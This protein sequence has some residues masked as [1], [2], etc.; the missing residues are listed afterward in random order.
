MVI[1]ALDHVRDFIHRGAMSFSPTDLART[2]T[3]I[4]LTRWIT[5]FCAPVFMFTAGM[6]AF[7]WWRQKRTRKQLSV[8]LLTRGLWLV[9]LE[10]TVMRVAYDFNFSARYPILLL[11]L[12]V[13]GA[14][15]VGMSVLVL[16]P[17][18]VLA[19][20]S[21]AVIALHNCMDGVTA[22]A[23]G[24]GAGV[25]NLIHQ[26]GAFQMAGMT[27]IVGYPLV[28]WIAVMSAGFCFGQ[29]FQMQPAM[30]RRILFLTGAACTLLFVIVRTINGYGDP[31]HWSAQKSMAG[32]LLSFLN[33]TKYPPSLAFLLMTLGP[34]LL[35]LSFFDRLSP[36]AANPLVIFG[37]VPLFYFILHFYAAHAVEVLLAWLRYG[38]ASLP[39]LFKP[40]PSMGSPRQLFPANFGYDLWV[41]YTIWAL[42][43][44]CL[45]P[46]CRW[47]G[48]VKAE[49]QVWWL[50]Y[51]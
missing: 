21:V 2:T 19:F 29:V 13:L 49:R 11:V 1:M 24:G 31:A 25:W 42:L 50:S 18:R 47:F 23:F 26:V 34:A 9:L 27:V 44:L 40:V 33:C 3:A 17:I 38:R 45:Y 14:C 12:W 4:F 32:T 6:S 39:F 16:L 36:K 7:L 35:L 8:F 37:R 20:L 28:P 30:R 43:V 10:L 22:P 46:A 15:M 5:H 48:R 51:V 41:V